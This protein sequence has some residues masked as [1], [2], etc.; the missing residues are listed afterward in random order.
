MTEEA[1]N[2]AGQVTV[3]E[4]TV[5]FDQQQNEEYPPIEPRQPQGVAENDQ[6]R[7]FYL[8]GG[9]VEIAAHLVYELDA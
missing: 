3:P 5:E 7:K 1:T 4:H 2:D 8:D 9:L 6:R